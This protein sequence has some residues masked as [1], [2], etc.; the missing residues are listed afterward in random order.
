MK[1]GGSFTWLCKR[2]TRPGKHQWTVDWSALFPAQS[3]RIPTVD[4]LV[5]STIYSSGYVKT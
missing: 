2:L 5:D 4:E 3:Y 1:K